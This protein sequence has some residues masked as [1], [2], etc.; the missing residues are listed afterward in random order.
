[1]GMTITV[2]RVLLVSTLSSLVPHSTSLPSSFNASLPLASVT[3]SE[4]LTSTVLRF[5]VPTSRRCGGRRK[6]CAR[7]NGASSSYSSP[8][9]P[10]PTRIGQS[11]LLNRVNASHYVG[12]YKLVVEVGWGISIG[13]YD[14]TKPGWKSGVV[15][16]SS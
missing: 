5:V 1:M 12:T 14:K 16:T 8:P 13:I 3:I 7:G 11:V 10:P 9:P 2:H 4:Y 6:G 15:V